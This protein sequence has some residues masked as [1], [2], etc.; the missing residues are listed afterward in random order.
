[1]GD[2]NQELDVLGMLSVMA[3]V[4]QVATY[5]EATNIE[6][7]TDIMKALQLQNEQYLKVIVNELREISKKQD[8]ILE[9]LNKGE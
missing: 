6:T 4:F 2:N 9:K 3:N 5:M 1:M 8:L 7:N